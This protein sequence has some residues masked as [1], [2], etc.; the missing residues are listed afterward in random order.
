MLPVGRFYTFG[1]K[2]PITVDQFYN[3]LN[4]GVIGVGKVSY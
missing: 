1:R 3:L 2:H 4:G